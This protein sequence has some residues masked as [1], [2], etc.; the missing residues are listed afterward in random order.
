MQDIF[1]FV[2]N[3]NTE[4]DPEESKERRFEEKVRERVS[5]SNILIVVFT[6]LF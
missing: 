6:F 3:E 1:Q 5:S 4:T 2:R